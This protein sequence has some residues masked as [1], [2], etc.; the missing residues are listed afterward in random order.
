[1]H[2]AILTV[3]DARSGAQLLS[4]SHTGSKHQ[5]SSEDSVLPNNH[6]NLHSW[7]QGKKLADLQITVAHVKEQEPNHLT[8]HLCCV[9]EE[10][11]LSACKSE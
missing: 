1:M 2:A 3:P 10:A 9:S 5:N 11:E 8:K 4:R 7:S 6:F